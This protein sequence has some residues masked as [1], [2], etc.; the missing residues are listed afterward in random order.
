MG[1]M[2]EAPPGLKG[3]TEHQIAQM[4]SFLFRLS[5]N[6]N[7]ALNTLTPENYASATQL[8]IAGGASSGQNSDADPNLGA[9]YNELRA[10]INNTADIVTSEMDRISTE[11]NGKYTAVSA[12]WGAFHENISSTITATAKGVVESYGYDATLSTL[13]EK[14]AGFSAYRVSTEGY[15][16]QGFINY[17]DDGVPIIGIAIGQGLKSTTVTIGDKVIEQIDKNQNCAFYTANKVSFW[18]NGTEAAYLSSGKLFIRDVE[19]IGSVIFSGK[20]ML[21]TNGPFKIKWI[22]G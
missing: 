6:L 2:I 8:A 4:Y 20:W 18:V 13:N 22:G 12:E 14:A 17:D 16:R 7:V 11:L 15:I 9:S 1:F 19:I 10:L 3:T 5:E 21:T